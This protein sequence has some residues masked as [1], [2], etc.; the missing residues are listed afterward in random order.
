M[1]HM[2][3]TISG[4]LYASL[5]SSIDGSR[6]YSSHLY[7]VKVR[8]QL[9]NMFCFLRSQRIFATEN[10]VALTHPLVWACQNLVNPDSGHHTSL[11]TWFK[12]VRNKVFLMYS[13]LS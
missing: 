12:E 3:H 2:D 13:Y 6:K 1:I 9:E 8:M 11:D 10:C 4:H 5:M 7:V